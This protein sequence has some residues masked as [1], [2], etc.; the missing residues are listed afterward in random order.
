MAEG[1]YFDMVQLINFFSFMLK[2][3]CALDPEFEPRSV[4]PKV[5]PLITFR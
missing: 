3:F 2:S 1:F 5:L 4:S